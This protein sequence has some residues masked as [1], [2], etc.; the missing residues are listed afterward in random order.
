MRYDGH[1]DAGHDAQGQGAQLWVWRGERL[2]NGVD[3]Q[4]GS[5]WLGFGILEEIDVD[6]LLDWQG[7]G[8]NVLENRGEQEGRL[9]GVW[10]TVGELRM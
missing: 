9:I 10:F 1:A 6:E 4:E 5:V 8:G 7:W 3:C 2:L